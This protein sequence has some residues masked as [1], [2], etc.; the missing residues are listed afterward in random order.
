LV[1]GIEI[2]S[3]TG[4]SQHSRFEI[5]STKIPNTTHFFHGLKLKFKESPPKKDKEKKNQE[6]L[7]QRSI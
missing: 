6:G 7:G 3:E 4:E 5:D 2:F 1:V